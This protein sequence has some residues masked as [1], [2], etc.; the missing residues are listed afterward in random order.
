MMLGIAPQSSR[1]LLRF[2][3]VALA[4]TINA[5]SMY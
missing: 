3:L 5:A 4:V 2:A 1:E